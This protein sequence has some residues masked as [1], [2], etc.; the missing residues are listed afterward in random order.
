MKTITKFIIAIA[1][2]TMLVSWKDPLSTRIT[3]YV[4][5]VE[6]N[7]SDW[8]KDDWNKSEEKYIELL[9]EYKQN[10]DSYSEEDRSIINKAIG[11]YNGIVVKK[12][13]KGAGQKIKNFGKR[14]PSLMEG[15]VSA[16]DQ[17]KE[18]DQEQVQ[19]EAQSEVLIEG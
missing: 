1:A 13:I 9:E 2:I 18:K 17:N 15:F 19:E 8:T 14:L 4:D 6:Q 16:F 11:K 5:Q 3:E 12:G 7:C 10:Y